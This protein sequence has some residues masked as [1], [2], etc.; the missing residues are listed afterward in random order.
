MFVNELIKIIAKMERE[1]S[2]CLSG[3]TQEGLEKQ[4]GE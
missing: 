3:H 4:E 1:E 2:R